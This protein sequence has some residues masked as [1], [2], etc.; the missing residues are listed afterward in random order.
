MPKRFGKGGILLQRVEYNAGCAVSVMNA[1]IYV[2]TIYADPQKVNVFSHHHSFLELH[3]E[4]NGECEFRMNFSDAEVIGPG[5]WILLGSDVYH[6]ETVSE[7]SSGYCVRLEIRAADRDSPF[8]A[9]KDLG[10]I[11]G[12]A[13]PQ[14]AVILEQ[15]M[16]EIGERKPGYADAV[17]GML[18]VL[19]IQLV[20]QTDLPDSV[21]DRRRALPLDARTVIDDYFDLVFRQDGVQLSIGELADRLRVSP[22]HVSRI[23]QREY[24]TTFSK[25]LTE[26]RIRLAKHL[27]LHT[28]QSVRQ[29]SEQCGMSSVY[30]IRCFR[31]QTGFSPLQYRK[32]NKT[33]MM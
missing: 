28:D 11:R 6:E 32:E 25:K 5:E 31:E 20:R 14:T 29:I 15:I 27:L 23:L 19:L 3:F 21:E 10:W 24:G 8:W 18:T 4:V 17:R 2:S 26:V 30:L 33:D 7:N 13:A 22:R 9:W 16:R 1:E 12:A